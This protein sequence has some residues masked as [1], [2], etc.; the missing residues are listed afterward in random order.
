MTENE[1]AVLKALRRL[2]T[3]PLRGWISSAWHVAA[4]ASSTSLPLP[5]V[6]AT[7]DS[8]ARLGLA[9][10]LPMEWENTDWWI[11]VEQ[12]ET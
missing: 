6:C 2:P 3:Q 4:L 8:L 11:A 10:L 5:T 9:K 12:E 1:A 7:L